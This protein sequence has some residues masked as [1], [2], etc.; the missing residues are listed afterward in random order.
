MLPKLFSG[1]TL[2]FNMVQPSQAVL[3]SIFFM[4]FILLMTYLAFMALPR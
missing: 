3:T 1:I 4:V 2:N